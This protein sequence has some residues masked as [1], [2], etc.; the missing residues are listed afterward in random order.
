MWQNR[1]PKNSV[2]FSLVFMLFSSAF[3]DFRKSMFLHYET[4]LFAKWKTRSANH[5]NTNEKS[6]ATYFC[7]EFW[8]IFIGF[9][10]LLIGISELR[11]SNFLGYETQCYEGRESGSANHCFRESKWTPKVISRKFPLHFIDFI[12][13]FR[14]RIPGIENVTWSQ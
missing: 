3:F 6:V 4:A 7:S 13:D 11:K 10:A 12:K 5:A 2:P 9:H 14:S 8:F 1:F